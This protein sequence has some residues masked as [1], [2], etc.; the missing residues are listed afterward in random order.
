MKYFAYGS[1]MSSIRLQERVPS[2]D[3][4]G[5]ARLPGYELKWHKISKKDGS[6]KCDIVRSDREN[7]RVWGV[8]YEIDDEE[9]PC[10]DREEGLGYGYDEKLVEV[11]LDGQAVSAWTYYATRIDETLLPY[12]WYKDF[13]VQGAME[14]RLPEEYISL[15]GTTE[16]RR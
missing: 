10:L 12:E 4:I 8:L 16:V 3:A 5:P 6:G 13:V 7:T 2:A 9:K 15:L 14:H 11:D 1:N